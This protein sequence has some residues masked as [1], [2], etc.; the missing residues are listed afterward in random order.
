MFFFLKDTTIATTENAIDHKQNATPTKENS[1]LLIPLLAR[2]SK[3]H[4]KKTVD[5]TIPIIDIV[6]IAPFSNKLK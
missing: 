4:R 2:K 1:C 5:K 6:F 3:N